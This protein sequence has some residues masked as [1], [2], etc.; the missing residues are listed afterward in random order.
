MNDNP[1]PTPTALL[2]FKPSV[3]YFRKA[4]RE[5]ATRD[6]ALTVANV[7]TKEFERLRDWAAEKEILPPSNVH[8]A[9]DLLRQAIAASGSH[10]Q[11]IILGLFVCHE[12]EELKAII[13]DAGLIPPKWLIT[14]E[15]AAQKGWVGR[16]AVNQ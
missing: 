10:A 15:E 8:V 13:R 7:I 2:S 3:F 1:A 5:S 9:A 12:L 11:V 6:V 16:E 14:P 4:L